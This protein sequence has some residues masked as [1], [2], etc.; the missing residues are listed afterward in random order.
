MGHDVHP[1]PVIGDNGEHGRQ[2]VCAY[3]QPLAICQTNI[4][5]GQRSCKVLVKESKLHKK[6]LQNPTI[7]LNV[8]MVLRKALKTNRITSTQATS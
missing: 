4:D 2:S 7:P 6:N 8:P 1:F 3:V 5:I